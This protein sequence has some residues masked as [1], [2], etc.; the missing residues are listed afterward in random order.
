M[1]DIL[2]TQTIVDE[3]LRETKPHGTKQFPMAVYFDDFSVFE[4][5]YIC[6]HWHEEVQIT[7]IT[8][9]A[10]LCQVEKD[11]ILL[12]TGDIIF[13]NS[14]LLHQIRPY[15]A[16]I[17]KL[18]SFIFHPT[19]LRG[20]DDVYHTSILP[21][22]RH[23]LPFVL[24]PSRFSSTL[25]EIIELYMNRPAFYPL[26]IQYLLTG[27]WLELCKHL[28]DDSNNVAS[29]NLRDDERIKKAL[30]FM[31]ENYGEDLTLDKIAKA[32]LVSR[33]ELCRCFRRTLNQS[34]KEFLMQYRIRQACVLLKN[35]KLRITDI[36]EI[37][38]FSSPSHFGSYFH[39]YMNCT[40][41][42][43]RE[44]DCRIN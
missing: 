5:G 23:S 43:Y 10:F 25:Y 19:V 41:R 42:E 33:S 22:L 4:N 29:E 15:R 20:S 17:G 32:A 13:I 3:S 7:F 37:V 38:G 11:E 31:Q 16:N 44:K 40:P 36:A 18:Y 9:G 34:P 21:V 14:G 12:K 8:E 27:I 39:K 35:P 30:Q 24:L 2:V 6:W 26:T 1:N 28:S